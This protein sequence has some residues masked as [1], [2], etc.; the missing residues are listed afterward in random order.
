MTLSCLAPR[1]WTSEVP[2]SMCI[3]SVDVLGDLLFRHAQLHSSSSTC[4]VW[5]LRCTNAARVDCRSRYVY[6][7]YVDLRYGRKAFQQRS[8]CI[9]ENVPA[10]GT[11]CVPL[12]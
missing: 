5:H 10:C 11:L 2:D 12:M 6:Y 7:R 8:F 4:H 9:N 1:V 3:H